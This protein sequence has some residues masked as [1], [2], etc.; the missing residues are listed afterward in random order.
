MSFIIQPVTKPSIRSARV[1][2]VRQRVCARCPSAINFCDVSLL[3]RQLPDICEALVAAFNLAPDTT[4]V[5]DGVA[6]IYQDYRRGEDI[7]GLEWDSWC[8]FAVV[9]KEPKSESLV[10]EIG[11]WL[12]QSPWASP[13]EREV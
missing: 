9:A 8:G 3:V 6:L 10:R 2:H 13:G 5:T 4:L 11:N 12:L 7:I 1:I